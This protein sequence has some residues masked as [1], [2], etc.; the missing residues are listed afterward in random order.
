M[1]RRCLD[2]SAG[3]ES[4]LSWSLGEAQSLA[5]KAAR[6]AG[7]PWGMAEEAGY[8]LRWLSARGLPGA[9][10][11]ATLLATMNGDR[12]PP[13]DPAAPGWNPGPGALCPLALG[14]ALADDMTAV[15]AS[16]LLG[17]VRCPLLLVPFVAR[18]SPDDGLVLEWEAAGIAFSTGQVAAVGAPSALLAS[19]SIL[20]LRPGALAEAIPLG[21]TS[22]VPAEAAQEIEVLTRLAKRTYAPATEKSRLTGA[23]ARNIDD[24]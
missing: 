23:G 5:I 11:L 14:A 13:P 9:A 19:E 12:P 10:A 22:R 24:D 3:G 8:A 4:L 15:G 18:L 2:L 17:P 21:A 20:V 16:T 7:Y 6:G 1:R